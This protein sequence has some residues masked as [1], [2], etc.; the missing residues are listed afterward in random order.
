MI[1]QITIVM[2]SFV[3]IESLILLVKLNYFCCL[4][5]TVF[6]EHMMTSPR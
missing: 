1:E 3:F 5:Y 4:A 2:S 6:G